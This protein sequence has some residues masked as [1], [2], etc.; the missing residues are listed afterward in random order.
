[1][2]KFAIFSSN[3]IF[4]EKRIFKTLEFTEKKGTREFK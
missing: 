3:L 1:M 4:K 2:R